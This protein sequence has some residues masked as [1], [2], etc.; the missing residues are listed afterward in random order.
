[1]N[2][3]PP[4][5]HRPHIDPRLTRL[6]DA[7]PPAQPVPPFESRGELLALARS[8]QRAEQLRQ[9]HEFY[10]SMDTEAVA[11][12]AGLRIERH[13][14][15]SEPDG[16]RIY[17]Q[18][19]R[20][21]DDRLLPCVYYL[22]GGG[23]MGGSAF[24]GNYRAFGKL[25]A[26]NDVAVAMADFRNSL[27]PSSAGDVAPYPAGLNDCVSGFRWVLAEAPTLRIDPLTVII[28]G[29]SGGANL[30]LALVMRLI[31]AGEVDLVR[32]VYALCPYI[33]GK[34]PQDRYPS[35]LDC[36]GIL[37]DL[38]NDLGAVSYGIEALERQDPLAWP[39]F[40]TEDDVKGFPP[41]VIGV[42][43]FDPLRDEGIE[44]YRLLLRSG[45][46]ARCRQ[47]MGTV[48]G[49]E[50]LVSICPDISRD[51]A[52]SIAQFCRTF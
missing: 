21:D 41:T 13:E 9:E 49:T 6:L 24:D 29:E 1:M 22:H 25:L 17:L 23:M 11:P 32:G 45:V 42:N 10:D 44:F 4:A 12:S 31:I 20:P 3:M 18:L 50:L 15:T 48:H 34:W 36:N 40:A 52:A 33:A 43:E 28:A 8:P 35:S 19:I 14:L 37:L 27:I 2:W 46:A 26:A 38:H 7:L 47:T 16:N 39:G 5:Y 30:S 51:A